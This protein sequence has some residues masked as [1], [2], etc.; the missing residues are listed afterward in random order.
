MREYWQSVD[1]VL[2]Q[3]VHLSNDVIEDAYYLEGIDQLS[4]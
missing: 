2:R 4:V 1:I 3:C